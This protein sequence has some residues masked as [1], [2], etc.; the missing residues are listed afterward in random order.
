[1]SGLYRGDWEMERCDGGRDSTNIRNL[2]AASLALALTVYEMLQMTPTTSVLCSSGFRQRTHCL[3][4]R[5]RP[6]ALKLDRGSIYLQTPCTPF[7][8]KSR[9]SCSSCREVSS[10]KLTTEL[11]QTLQGKETSSKDLDE[12]AE[13]VHEEVTQV[14]RE[15]DELGKIF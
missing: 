15:R 5:T 4:N 3:P 2:V 10:C 6:W 11:N 13:L 14:K 8:S 12:S 1:M 9:S 7:A